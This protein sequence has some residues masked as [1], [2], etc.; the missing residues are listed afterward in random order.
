MIFVDRSIPKGVADALKL[1]RDDVIWLEDRFPHGT[2]DAVWLREAG[3][4]E[5]LVVSR[6]KRLRSRPGELRAILE[7]NVGCFCF[8]QKQAITRWEYLK[9]FARSLD[10]ME[11]IFATEPRPFVFGVGA[12]GIFRPLRLVRSRS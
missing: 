4:N 10:E 2:K 1:V 7:N 6:D 11:R 9:L 12:T 3:L 5:W 8:T